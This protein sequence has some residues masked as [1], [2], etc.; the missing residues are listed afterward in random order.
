[1][2]KGYDVGGVAA[3]IEKRLQEAAVL[4]LER[5]ET[6]RGVEYKVG[7]DYP[8]G[9]T[10]S[11]RGEVETMRKSLRQFVG[12]LG[13]AIVLIYLVMVALLRSFAVPLAILLTV[14]LGMIGVAIILYLTGTA[15]SIP[16]AMGILMMTGIVVEF[17]IILLTFANQLVAQGMAVQA[18]IL[19]AVKIRFRPILMTSMAAWLAMLPMAIGGPGAEANAPLARAIIGGVIAAAFL[20]LFVVPCL[21]VIFQRDRAA[22]AVAGA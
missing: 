7:G 10:I 12:G 20:S 4:G 11:M 15:L 8:K 19:E 9:Y 18:A 5:S 17:S 22:P 3:E 2:Q 16:A 1:V 6:S 14:P 13:M 21:Y